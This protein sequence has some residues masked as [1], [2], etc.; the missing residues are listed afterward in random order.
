MNWTRPHELRAQLQKLWD[1]GELLAALVTGDPL[2]PKRLTLKGPT[3][4]EIADRFDEVRAWVGEFRELPNCRVEMREFRHR[5][6]GA[7]AL[8]RGVWIDTVEDAMALIG[9]Q[10]AAARFTGL[11]GMTRELEPRLLTWLVRRPLRALELADEWRRLLEIVA[12]IENHPT[13]GVYLRQVDIPGVHTK[14]TCS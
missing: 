6:F 3:S 12:W 1:R 7:N 4:A 2:F 13:P 8:P 11:I 5:L 10:R 9:K 14:Y